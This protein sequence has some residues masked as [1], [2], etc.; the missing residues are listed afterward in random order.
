MHALKGLSN[1]LT[2]LQLSKN[3]QTK[4]Q[5]IKKYLH[6]W[7]SHQALQSISLFTSSF[8][9][10]LALKKT[11]WLTLSYQSLSWLSFLSSAQFCFKHINLLLRPVLL[12]SHSS[13]GI[14]NWP[15]NTCA[16]LIRIRLCSEAYSFI[17]LVWITAS[18]SY[19]LFTL[20]IGLCSVFSNTSFSQ[21][22]TLERMSIK[23][24]AVY[25]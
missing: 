19:S 15:P 6:V 9:L 4:Q 10:I 20:I 7:P 11:F 1:W 24:K 3:Y 12:F 2:R 5:S 22:V 18:P 14:I 8:C 13:S 23:I 16:I 21:R 25:I 17:P